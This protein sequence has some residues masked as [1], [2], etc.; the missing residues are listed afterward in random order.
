[1][2][3]GGRVDAPPILPAPRAGHWVG[4]AL[5]GIFGRA[6]DGRRIELDLRSRREARPLALA[7]VLTLA[8]ASVAGYAANSTFA[9]RYASVFFPF[10]ILL[11][12]LGLSHLGGRRVLLGALA[13][14]LEGAAQDGS[15][16]VATGRDGSVTHSLHDPGYSAA[17]ATPANSS[18]SPV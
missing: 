10:F 18:A 3:A 4:V 16:P 7:V 8:I 17:P 14:L 15:S 11:A 6:I 12:A 9:S 2:N 13:V 5:L 1:M